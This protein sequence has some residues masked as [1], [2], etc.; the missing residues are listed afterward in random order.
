MRREVMGGQPTDYSDWL[1]GKCAHLSSE[2]VA[3]LS[4]FSMVFCS[5]I[6]FSR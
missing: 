6:F 3:D 4:A 5:L 1:R 2:P